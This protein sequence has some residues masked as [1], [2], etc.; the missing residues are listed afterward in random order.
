MEAMNAGAPPRG[1]AKARPPHQ[2]AIAEHPEL[3]HLAG[4]CGSIAK[5]IG[6]ANGFSTCSIWRAL[7]PAL[8]VLVSHGLVRLLVLAIGRSAPLFDSEKRRLADRGG[9][10]QCGEKIGAA[11]L[12][13]RIR[14]RAATV[15]V[16][17]NDGLIAAPSDL[18]RC[19]QAYDFRRVAAA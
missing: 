5:G 7:L 19:M 6:K 1:E 8:L 2:R 11:F 9:S 15:F 17:A 12:S 14:L 10:F 16:S 4:H 13:P 3:P 18:L